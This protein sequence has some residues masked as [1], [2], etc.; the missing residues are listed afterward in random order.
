MRVG[1]SLWHL[2]DNQSVIREEAVESS[3]PD[4]C[5]IQS[6]YSLISSGTERLVAQGK[7][8]ES[9]FNEMKVPYMEGSFRFPIKYGY[10]LVGKVVSEGHKLY[11]KN[12]HLMHPHQDFCIV[13]NVDLFEIPDGI[14]TERATL[15]S[16]LE[17]VLTALW[18]AQVNIGDRVLIV[19]FGLIGSLLARLLSMMPA[20][21]FKIF[22]IDSDRK[23]M[24]EIFGFQVIDNAN[25]FSK[26][27]I[28]FH[29]SA[30]SIGLQHCI[31]SVGFEGKVVDLSWY[32]TKK[33]ALNLGG[34]FH[35]QRKQIISSQVG[36][37]PSSHIGRWDFK[38][39]KKVVFELLK[40]EIF[41]QHLTHFIDFVDSPAF[42]TDIRAN[43]AK[44]L[45]YCIKY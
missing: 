17:T 32:G 15:A 18:D 14:P 23:K 41:D 3:R 21:D 2:S 4:F 44:G 7:V 33:V 38:R 45:A 11:G 26:V 34:S 16:N 5:E 10:S 25:D 27:D 39:R 24:A 22:E 35:N 20:V 6:R 28:A 31:D 29:T 40:N 36:N 13:K 30:S 8:P 42:F 12:V 43:K 19:G 9:L 37:I 1:R